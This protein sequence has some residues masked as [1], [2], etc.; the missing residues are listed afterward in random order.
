MRAD[1]TD[2][3]R[4]VVSEFALLYGN[5]WF[6]V[7]C[8]QP[9]GTLAELEGV[10]VTDVF[11][12][13]TLVEPTV[14]SAGGNWTEWDTFSLSPRASTAPVLALPQH[15]FTPASL[16]HIIDG[17]PLESVAFVRD[18]GADLVW[19]VEQRVPDGLGSSRDGAEAARRLRQEL[20]P[21]NAAADGPASLRYLA[22]TEVAEH[23]IP[24]IAVHKPNETRKIRLQRAAIQRVVPP[25]GSLIRPVTSILREGLTDDD[26]S[27]KSQSYFLNEEE[28]P[29]AGVVVTGR[30]R[31]A[32]RFD[33][34][35]VV[36]AARSVAT[37]RGGGR[38][39]LAFDRVASQAPVAGHGPGS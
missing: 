9:V 36:W 14:G 13:R 35:P 11:G 24:F 3:A 16:G 5:N 17:E 29:R 6:V 31:R 30:W 34:T 21:T 12:W 2:A 15:L 8:R 7:T 20:A 38:S 18:E 25:V 4:I 19:A 1:T 22:Q 26:D 10:V 32:R 37:G 28:V 33:G 23:W 39:G 27:T